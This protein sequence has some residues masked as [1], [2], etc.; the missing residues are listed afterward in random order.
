MSL[1]D[2]VNSISGFTG[3]KDSDRIRF[4][5]W[6]LH[7]KRNKE[8]FSPADI[9]ACYEELSLNKPSD[10]NPYLS[11]MTARKPPEMVKDKRGY[12]LEKR[13]RDK[14]ESKYGQRAATVVVDKMLLDLPNQV[15]NLVERTFLD[16]TIRCYRAEAFRA[17]I[18]MAWNLA[19]HHLC[20]FILKNH[21]AAFNAQWPLT[22]PGHHKD[23]KIKAIA[24]HDDFA[25][26]KES[27]MIQVC[28][29]ANII[30][31]DLRKVLDEKLGRRNSAAH[32]SSVS[33]SPHTAEECVIDLI[34]NVVLKLV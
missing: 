10:V 32:P 9:R 6:F 14:L 13:L 33:F 25:V 12:A 27:Q 15:P 8:R 28:R 34:T 22:L 11:Q 19:Y 7:S 21:L 5:A 4:F 20:D 18:V 24:T 26:L 2:L 17:T 29:S 30:T 1:E 23:S 16:E 3:W 31:N